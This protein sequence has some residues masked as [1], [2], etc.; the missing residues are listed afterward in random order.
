MSNTHYASTLNVKIRLCLNVLR[1]TFFE[2]AV[3]PCT[4]TGNCHIKLVHG[5][6]FVLH[7]VL[8][9]PN[10]ILSLDYFSYIL[11]QL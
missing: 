3:Y 7:R 10:Y 8:R 1:T 4:R 6:T 9:L 5:T 2:L 11:Q